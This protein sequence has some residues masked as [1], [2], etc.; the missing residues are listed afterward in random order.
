MVPPSQ[1]KHC[2]GEDNPSDL[3]LREI[4]MLELK[5]SNAW[6][7]RPSWLTNLE[8]ETCAVTEMPDECAL[9]L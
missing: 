5:A 1:L 6:F 8:V 3:P 2:P 4:S 9:E 7:N